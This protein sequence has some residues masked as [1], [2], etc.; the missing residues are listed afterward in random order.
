MIKALKIFNFFS[1][2]GLVFLLISF[3]SMK[4]T[5]AQTKKRD[6]INDGFIKA[7]VIKSEIENCGF[8]LE[9]ENKERLMPM[10]EW[11]KKLK[12]N[13]VRVWLKYHSPKG[14]IMSTCMGGKAIEIEEI[15]KR[16]KK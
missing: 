3:L 15:Y 11:N 5:N 12:K 9:N 7:T 1:G 8:L 2:S 10:N 14:N 4:E 6:W 13:N 16:K